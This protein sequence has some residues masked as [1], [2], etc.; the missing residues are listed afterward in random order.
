[1]IGDGSGSAATTQRG[2][3]NHAARHDPDNC[4]RVTALDRYGVTQY[5]TTAAESRLPQSI[6]DE[7][8]LLLTR[9]FGAFRAE[10][11]ADDRIDFDDVEERG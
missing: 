5:I 9:S 10:A 8:P 1:M 11:A 7:D 2:R 4:Q 3:G 6:A